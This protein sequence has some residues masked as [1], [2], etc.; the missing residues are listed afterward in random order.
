MDEVV[1][2]STVPPGTRP[3]A[4]D[5]L[6]VAGSGGVVWSLSPEGFHTNLVVLA[7]GERIA[8]HRNDEID[9]LFVTL[10]GDGTLTVDDVRSE[11]TVGTALLVPRGTAR[12]IAAGPSGIRYLTVHAQRRPLTIGLR[13]GRR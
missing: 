2:P 11:L 13:P 7:T 5:L 6:R 9:V 10:D 3:L 4:V 8:T 12:S 1:E